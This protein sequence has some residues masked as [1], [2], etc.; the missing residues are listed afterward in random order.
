MKLSN[1]H[2]YFNGLCCGCN[3]AVK[4]EDVDPDKL[5]LQWLCPRCRAE[6]EQLPLRHKTVF[7]KLKR[8]IEDVEGKVKHLEHS[9]AVLEGFIIAHGLD[10]QAADDSYANA[11]NC[12]ANRAAPAWRRRL[13]CAKCGACAGHPEDRD[14]DKC[15]HCGERAT[16]DQERDS[17]GAWIT[18]P[19]PSSRGG[20]MR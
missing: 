3:A 10:P 12:F 5:Y 13:L 11:L 1:V 7:D 19:A 9:K 16:V 8:K 20:G 4:Q 17:S 15:R 6:L 14:G 18:S 2:E